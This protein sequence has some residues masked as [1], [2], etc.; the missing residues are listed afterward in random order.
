MTK[1][2][3]Y[4][5]RV[6]VSYSHEDKAMVE[7]IVDVLK[8]NGL[9][10]MWDRN[11]YSG[12]GFHDQIKNFI[13][14]AHV[15]MPFIT[16]ASSGRGWVHQEIGYAMALN[17]PVLS[18]TLD[19]VPGEFL[20]QLLSIPFSHDRNELK[21]KLT[22]DVFHRRVSSA[23]RKSSPLFYCATHREDRTRT[24]IEYASNVLELE[25]YGHVRQK[26]G[27]SSFHI[28]DKPANH[29]DFKDRFGT[30][31]SEHRCISLRDER[32]VLESHAREAGCSLIVDP[33]L[34]FSYFGPQAKIARLKTL[35]EFLESMEN[36][37]IA[38]AIVK[39]DQKEEDHLTIVGDWFVAESASASMGRGIRQTIF[40]RHAPSIMNR[41]ET[42]DQEFKEH[43][44]ALG[45]TAET[46]RTKAIKTMKEII[47]DLKKS[48]VKSKNK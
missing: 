10:P 46:S 13:A 34:D 21:E 36:D 14:H 45:W 6:F 16:E 38:V 33:Q 17:V 8:E 48:S 20:Q 24:M 30:H 43:L 32:R 25:E 11:F 12:E 1:A 23:Q 40:T 41:I 47:A 37:K 35:I 3:N 5:Y 27:L 42:F 29:K 28:P 15:F 26:G 9:K 19:R 31:F 18:I 4:T 2:K 39:P 44:D 7:M 22:K